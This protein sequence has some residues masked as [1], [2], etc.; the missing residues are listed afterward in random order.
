MLGRLRAAEPDLDAQMRLCAGKPS[1]GHGW[2]G[3][4]ESLLEVCGSRQAC[5]RLPP[6]CPPHARTHVHTHTHNAHAH[7]LSLPPSLPPFPPLHVILSRARARAVPP[8]LP[9][10]LSV[11]LARSL[12]LSVARRSLLTYSL[13]SPLSPTYAQCMHTSIH[14]CSRMQTSTLTLLCATSCAVQTFTNKG[15]GTCVIGENGSGEVDEAGWEADKQAS[16][17]VFVYSSALKG[18]ALALSREVVCLAFSCVS[19][20]MRCKDSILRVFWTGGGRPFC[21]PPAHAGFESLFS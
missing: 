3:A 14:I 8:S 17:T 16:L 19:T 18:A 9:L 7:A 4:L 13:S 21:C 20:E 2:I 15:Y 5:P 12:S 1:D 10:I 6:A 11:A